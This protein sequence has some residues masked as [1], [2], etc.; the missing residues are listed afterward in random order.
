MV[1][2]SS[3]ILLIL[4]LSFSVYSREN[5]KISALDNSQWVFS[6]N[7][8]I[9]SMAHEIKGLGVAKII[10]EAGEELRLE[11]KS[12]QL[13]E[14]TEYRSVY[15]VPPVWS[16]DTAK[17]IDDIGEV[18]YSQATGNLIINSANSVFEHL[19]QGAWIK[20]ILNNGRQINDGVVLSN[21]NFAVPAEAFAACRNN[22]MP[23]NYQQ[24]RNSEFYFE[25][26]S[27]TLSKYSHRA[28]GGISEYVKATPSI[29]KILIDGYSDN[30]GRTGVKL[31]MSKERAEEVAALLIEFGIPHTMIQIRSHGDR[32]PIANNAHE[33]GRKK[34]RRVTV[35]LIKK[36]AAGK[37]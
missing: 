28:L 6:G 5:V 11:L 32:Y 7:N 33:A 30:R 14:L 8:T 29:S 15:R 2:R 25:S 3:I 23:V 22:L 27:T 18:F 24:V 31:R 21:I 10:A 4:L 35:R 12:N 19:K 17:Y 20:V 26:G 34:N 9:C 1:R 16:R 13:T 37:S 36:S